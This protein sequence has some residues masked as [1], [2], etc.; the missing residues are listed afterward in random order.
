MA[1]TPSRRRLILEA[2][3]AR[4]QVIEVANDYATDAGQH[5]YLGVTPALGIDDEDVA[6]ALVV[7]DEEPRYQGVSLLIA[8]PVEIQALAKAD[9]DEPWVAVED[10]IADIKRAVELEDRT[11]GGLVKRQIE[12]GS[13]TTLERPDGGTT[14][15][16]SVTYLC[17]Y[18]EN[19]GAP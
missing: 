12:R 7:G 2:L 9:L 3:L 14:V 10:V 17:P 8:L 5:V 6:I 18:A 15:G 16:A 11:L 13:V 1:A 19:W 4:L